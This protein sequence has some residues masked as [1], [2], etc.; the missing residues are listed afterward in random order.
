MHDLF[1]PM[2]DAIRLGNVY[3]LEYLIS[4]NKMILNSKESYSSTPLHGIVEQCNNNSFDKIH[5]CIEMVKLV[6][7][8]IEDINLRNRYGNTIL[9]EV[10]KKC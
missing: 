5:R 8:K 4:K 3:I 9:D 10:V 6:L 1:N 2:Y 7:P